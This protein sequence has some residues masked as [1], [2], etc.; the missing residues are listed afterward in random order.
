[1]G[2]LCFTNTAC[3]LQPMHSPLPF[4]PLP[5]YIVLNQSKF[6]AITEDNLN[7]AQMIEFIFRKFENIMGK[8][9]NTGYQHLLLFKYVSKTISQG[10]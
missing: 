4:N 9:E 6:K 10:R 7:V 1:M 2:H 8:E 3:C 5:N